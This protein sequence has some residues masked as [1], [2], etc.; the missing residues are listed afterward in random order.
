MKTFKVLLA[1]AVVLICQIL[2]AQKTYYAFTYQNSDGLTDSLSTEIVKPEYD[3]YRISK[4][5]KLYVFYHSYP[6]KLPSLCFDTKTE[7]SDKKYHS[8]YLDDVLISDEFY[9][10]FKDDK[11]AYLK[12]ADTDAIV[13]PQEDIYSI[14]NLGSAFIIA[15]FHPKDADLPKSKSPGNDKNGYPLPPKM[16]EIRDDFYAIYA[17]TLPLKPLLKIESEIFVPLYETNEI[18]DIYIKNIRKFNSVNFDYLTFKKHNNL[19]LY[20]KNLKLI[21]KIVI[22]NS[23]SKGQIDKDFIESEVSKAI[24]K[25]V[26]S[27]FNIYPTMASR[28]DENSEKKRDNFELKKS[29]SGLYELIRTKDEKVC[30]TMPHKASYDESRNLRVSIEQPGDKS[31]YF[32]LN[33]ETGIP[34]LPAKYINLLQ[35]NLAL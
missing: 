3:Y 12:N 14:E 10:Y 1:L 9:H 21:K 25:K 17:N 30:F 8:V 7:S 34:Y 2:Q 28:H 29:E 6:S 18:D 32:H 19:Y 22:P 11:K 15:K 24:G 13:K 26:Y 31:T 33:K 5:K 35:I 16:L 4:N 27:N 23:K 20:D